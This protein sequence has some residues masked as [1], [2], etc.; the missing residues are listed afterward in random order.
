MI[1]LAGK[2]D[3]EHSERLKHTT[4][5]SQ[6]P[7]GF[8][9]IIHPNHPLCGQQVELIRIRRGADPDLVVRMPDGHHGSIAMSWTDYAVPISSP[10]PPPTYLLDLQGLRQLAQFIQH[11]G[12][13]QPPAP[14]RLENIAT[15]SEE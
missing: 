4:P 12:Q 1:S 13:T 5:F 14:T 3:L 7:L 11:M 15:P 8:V 2:S 9:T 10:P 6:S